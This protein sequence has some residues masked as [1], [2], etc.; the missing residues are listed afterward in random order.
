MSLRNISYLVS[1]IPGLLAILGNV[2]GGYWTLS[3]AAFSLLV[4]GLLD[5]FAGKERKNAHTENRDPF[6]ELIL[7]LHV[8]VQS[9]VLI[10]FLMGIYNQIL[11]DAWVYWAAFSTGVAAG[12]GGIVPAHELIHKANPLKQFFGKYLLM[13]CGNV[14]FFTHHLRIHHRFVATG[15]DSATARKGES[16]YAF[17]WRTIPG[18]YREAWQSEAEMLGKKGQSAFSPGNILWVQ[19]IIQIAFLPVVF[20]VFGPTALVAWLLYVLVAHVLLEYVNYI[21]HYGLYRNHDERVSELHSWNS[22]SR[23]SRYLLVDLSRHA[24]HHFYASKPYH[25]LQTYDNAPE[26]P[27]GY[28]ALLVPALIPPLWKALIHPRLENWEQNRNA[29]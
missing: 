10:S 7:Y 29:A 20:F 23:I 16:L 2:K 28:A 11:V 15:H 6:P 22:D 8:A 9:A 3:A 13:S 27:G 5:W 12:I 26:L 18:Q 19:T 25:T 1:L 14:Y 4:L 21:E 24:D 17:M